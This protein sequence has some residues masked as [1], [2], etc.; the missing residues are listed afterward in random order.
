MQDSTTLF[1]S[2]LDQPRIAPD[3]VGA[4]DLVLIGAP[5]GTPYP[6]RN[7]VSYAVETLSAGAPQAIRD[8][9][10]ECSSN[11]DHYDFDL[12][13]TLLAD[14]G[15][16]LVDCGDLA[17]TPQ[18]GPANRAAIQEATDAI[19]GRGGTP[20]LLGGDDSVPIPFLAAF[21]D[22]RPVDILQID[23]HIDWRD[24]I[25]GERMGY[26]STIRRAS[27]HDFV[28]SIT[29]VGMRGVGSAR[30]AEVDA[31][32]DWGARLVTVGETRE[33]GPRGIAALIPEGG[34]LVIQIDCDAFDTS[35]CPAVNAPTPGGF[36]F[37]ELAALV[38]TVI[39]ARGLAGYSIV[40]LVPGEDRNMISAIA[41]A[42]ITCN[43]IGALARHGQ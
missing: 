40:E 34:N 14:S 19:L 18:D 8:A 10:N 27:E 31:A 37:E 20:F 33:L 32:R 24:S 6:D 23:A 3:A 39:E 42:R 5:H 15:R 2:F 26:S 43:A 1:R 11:I 25:G 13:G 30:A 29:Q 38:R 28:R 12:G 22:R 41:A 21:R 36:M 7:E 17:L 9:A 16:R 4:S 35:V